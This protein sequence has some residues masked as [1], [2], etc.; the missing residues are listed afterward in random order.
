M[1]KNWKHSGKN[2]SSPGAKAAA[3]KAIAKAPKPKAAWNPRHREKT[4]YKYEA[5][6][7][8]AKNKPKRR[9]RF[10]PTKSGRCATI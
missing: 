4:G 7:T 9:P 5:V 8:K 6:K 3:S 10:D 1:P 2:S